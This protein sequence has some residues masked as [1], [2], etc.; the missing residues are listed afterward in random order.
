MDIKW[1]VDEQMNAVANSGCKL[2]AT[3][4]ILN[5]MLM[6]ESDTVM[7]YQYAKQALIKLWAEDERK[8][9]VLAKMV[10]NIIADEQNHIESFNKAAAIVIGAKEPKAD[11]YNKAVKAE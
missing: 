8:A 2:A 3:N 11:E 6:A 1:I 10:D 9:Q 5:S 7:Q 4:G